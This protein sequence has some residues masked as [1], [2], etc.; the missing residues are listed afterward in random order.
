MVVL[1]VD[2]QMSVVSGLISG[3][4]WGKL[5]I[6]KVLKAYNTYE[7]RALLESQKVDIMLCDIEMPAEDGLSLFR[8]VKERKLNME[9]I[10][11]TAH[12]DFMYAREAVNL[13]GFDYILQPARYEDIENSILRAQQKIISN[14][15]NQ[16]YSFYGQIFYEKK[17]KLIDGIMRDWFY[18]KE[19][20]ISRI[21]DDF[22]K[23]DINIDANHSFYLVLFNVLR[24]HP[25]AEQWET[26]LFKASLNN[27]I[28]ELY[29][30]YDQ[31]VLL[32]E[33]DKDNYIFLLFNRNN[34]LIDE[35]GLVRQLDYF[36]QVCKNFFRCSIACYTGS[37]MHPN[38][39]S[40]KIKNLIKLKTDNVTLTSKVIFYE[41]E[42]PKKEEIHDLYNMRR[43][44]SLL[45]SGG[46]LVVKEEITAY[47]KKLS[48]SEK[49]GADSLK[50]FYQSYLQMLFNTAEH[51]NISLYTLFQDKEILEKSLNS[52]HTID[53]MYDFVNLTMDF[54]N[55]S[56]NMNMDTQ[57]QIDLIIQY[58]HNNIE[59]DIRRSEIAEAV[60]LN[61]DYMSRLFKKEVGTSLKEYIMLCKM[62]EAQTLLKNTNL[63]IS[64]IA[65]K[66]GYTNFS[67]FSQ[68]YKKMLG[69][70]PAEDRNN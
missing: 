52:Y 42:T 44:A 51:L 70:S 69:I 23:L 27:I 45:E 24:W 16:E 64:M 57:N 35:E 50:R 17:D 25:Q 41:K 36:I 46:A 63:P 32:A 9:C 58:I 68:V 66:V 39:V 56:K 6:T 21:W 13:G 48:E 54:F 34:R 37:K 40:E 49:L 60:F 28:S 26:Q 67:H 3:I 61:Q 30:H 12:A 7:A 53:Q 47:L 55:Q 65:A 14:R 43:W 11:L 31:K 5:Q 62:K 19:T 15:R 8:W 22:K 1:I 33:L 18:G 10:F 38:E 29:E 59:K 4:N 20:E 2:D